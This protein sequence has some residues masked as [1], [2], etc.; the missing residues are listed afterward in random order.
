MTDHAGVIA[1]GG[2][3]GL[4]GAGEV[5][6][7]GVDVAMVE[8][9]ARQDLDGSRAGGLA[10]RTSEVLDQ[11]GSADRF[12]AAGHV[13]PAMGFAGTVVDSSDV[14]PATTTCWRGGRA[15]SRPSW[16]TGSVSAGVRSC[17][18]AWLGAALTTTPASRSRWPRASRSARRISAAAT[19]GAAWS[20]RPPAS[21][22]S[23]G[24]LRPAT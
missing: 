19:E 21:P 7:A 4:M 15:T 6:V 5:A 8:R 13:H 17:V 12:L 20:A 1:G 18:V 11:R 3:T 23:G 9:R 16:L 24:I 22:S 10:A 2:P 14:P